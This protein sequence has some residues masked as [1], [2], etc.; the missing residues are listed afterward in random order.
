MIR[1]VVIMGPTAVGKSAAAIRLALD[2][3]GE[4]I[5]ADS[6]QVYKGLRIGTAAP[7]P[8]DFQ[9]C[10]HHL[11]HVLDLDQQP[12][13]A[14][15]AK[16][17]AAVIKDVHSRGRLPIVVGGT[18]FWIRTLFDGIAQVPRVPHLDPDAF[19]DPHAELMRVDPALASRL[20][21]ADLQRIMR[22]LDVYYATGRP[23]SDFHALDNLKFGNFQTL[24]LWLDMDRDQLYQRIDRRVDRMLQA[25]LVQE[26]QA[27]LDRGI[28]PNLPPLRTGGYRYVVDHC[29]GRMGLDEM[30]ARTAR[31][32]RNY[33][34]RQL[35]WLRR[36]LRENR[37]ERLDAGDYDALADR[38]GRFLRV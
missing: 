4:A 29:L 20:H 36:E 10:P 24:R 2:M 22:G 25:G 21:P 18:F 15:Y 9:Q 31:E 3:G 34:R 17:A 30:R 32:H 37:L 1:V 12:D 35:I 7:G 38:A 6:M 26:V 5:N 33:A 11:F 16:Q 13:A 8:E 19:T 14:W 23:L 27:L 28:S